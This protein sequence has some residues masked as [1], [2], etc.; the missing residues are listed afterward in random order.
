MTAVARLLP[1]PALSSYGER[2]PATLL[3]VIARASYGARAPRMLWSARGSA[4]VPDVLDELGASLLLS[5]PLVICCWWYAWAA[6]YPLLIVHNHCT[7]TTN[8]AY[9]SHYYFLYPFTVKQTYYLCSDQTT[10][11]DNSAKCQ[12]INMEWLLDCGYRI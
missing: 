5:Y 12:L 10:L 8:K 9:S 1:E 7:V 2:V 3:R 4:H 6:Y 11:T